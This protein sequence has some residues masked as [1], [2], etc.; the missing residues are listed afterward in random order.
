M[1]IYCLCQLNAWPSEH[2]HDK[3]HRVHPK[4]LYIK[5]LPICKR[6]ALAACCP[7]FRRKWSVKMQKVCSA[8]LWPCFLPERVTWIKNILRDLQDI[9]EW[10]EKLSTGWEKNEEKLKNVDAKSLFHII[11]NQPMW[12]KNKCSYAV[13]SWNIKI[14]YSCSTPTL[15]YFVGHLCLVHVTIC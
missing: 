11:H 14:Y 3:F 10:L 15:K 5:G 8:H 4:P 12:F 7:L 6:R 2:S 1:W 9:Y 13:L